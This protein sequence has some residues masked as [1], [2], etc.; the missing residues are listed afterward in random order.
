M[1]IIIVCLFL[2]LSNFSV[3]RELIKPEL[4]Y[5]KTVAV[6]KIDGV[7]VSVDTGCRVDNT[8][9]PS[10]NCSS[11][12]IDIKVDNDFV[13]NGATSIK[14]ASLSVGGV[15]LSTYYPLMS[16]RNPVHDGR[17][18]YKELGR[19][20]NAELLLKV[21]RVE[22]INDGSLLTP[23]VEKTLSKT[24]VLSEFA[25]TS[26]EAAANS[27]SMQE[28][29]VSSKW[30]ESI[31][32]LVLVVLL[33]GGV[34]WL[35]IKIIIACSKFA[36]VRAGKNMERRRVRRVAEDEAIRATIRKSFD[37]ADEKE[38]QS[39]KGQIK[40][41]LDSGDTDTAQ[42]LMSL[43]TKYSSLECSGSVAACADKD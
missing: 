2:V 20:Q 1:R 36:L 11:P 4:E 9:Y 13:G 38:L 33:V 10:I 21:V 39:L 40:A 7:V 3:A 25:E 29:Y 30:R 15:E 8:N 17:A 19:S 6:W 18:L 14:S 35:L 16:D 12:Y 32:Y 5:G 26:R 27:K 34:V 37:L 24:I 28:A 42:N 41:A 23:S 43:L 31:G 22:A